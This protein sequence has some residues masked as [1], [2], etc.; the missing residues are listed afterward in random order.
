MPFSKHRTAKPPGD[1]R[2]T[3]FWSCSSLKGYVLD[4]VINLMVISVMSALILLEVESGLLNYCY[5]IWARFKGRLEPFNA[6]AG[7]KLNTC[8]TNTTTVAYSAGKLAKC[9]RQRTCPCIPSRSTCLDSGQVELAADHAHIFPY[10]YVARSVV[11]NRSREKWIW[12]PES[13]EQ[14]YETAIKFVAEMDE[15]YIQSIQK[16][17]RHFACRTI[18]W[19]AHLCSILYRYGQVGRRVAISVAY[20]CAIRHQ[21]H[22]FTA[23]VCT[24]H[25]RLFKVASWNALRDVG[26]CGE[27][28]ILVQYGLYNVLLYHVDIA[29]TIDV[30]PIIS[31]AKMVPSSLCGGILH[32]GNFTFRWYYVLVSNS[33]FDGCNWNT[34]H[35]Y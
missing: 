34:I 24:F 19:S 5:C 15:M 23:S 21:L 18:V 29:T 25:T 11:G 17:V 30:R 4:C 13:L 1:V 26:V 33:F 12:G 14:I 22:R 2:A 31:M 9:P 6:S 10:S 7:C 28:Q 35:F 27:H 16:S 32:Q 3:K 8:N 20:I